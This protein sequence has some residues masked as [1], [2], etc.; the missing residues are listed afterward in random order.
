[1]KLF[2]PDQILDNQVPQNGK[3]TILIV[4]I[5]LLLLQAFKEN[6]QVVIDSYRGH[7]VVQVLM[8]QANKFKE[9]LYDT[10]QFQMV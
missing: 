5:I 1:M 4:V 8:T 3:K 6:I 9:Y 2:E 10:I 7:R